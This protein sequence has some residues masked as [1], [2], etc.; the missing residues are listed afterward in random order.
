M[1]LIFLTLAKIG[2]ILQSPVKKESIVTVLWHGVENVNWDTKPTPVRPVVVR[3]RTALYCNTPQNT[4]SLS[5]KGWIYENKI[6]K[7]IPGA[8]CIRIAQ[9]PIKTLFRD[10]TSLLNMGGVKLW[11]QTFNQYWW[12]GWVS[13]KGLS[14][15]H[16]TVIL[17]PNNSKND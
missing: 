6:G 1:W 7:G 11:W 16:C 17:T 9:G 5:E 15:L 3:Y 14:S 13:I 12:R 4:V 10:Y 2:Y 8:H